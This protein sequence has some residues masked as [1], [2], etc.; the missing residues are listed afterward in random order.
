MV[1]LLSLAAVAARESES[2]ARNEIVSLYVTYLQSEL[3]QNGVLAL[4]MMSRSVHF[5]ES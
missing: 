5:G 2:Q 4:G 3:N 1:K